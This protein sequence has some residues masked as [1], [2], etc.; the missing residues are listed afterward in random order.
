MILTT[1]VRASRFGKRGHEGE[2][3]RFTINENR[4]QQGPLQTTGVMATS[5][6]E[7]SLLPCR[8]QAQDWQVLQTLKRTQTF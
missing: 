7:D 8:T 1:G 4:E 3:V 5:A 6:R 2:Q